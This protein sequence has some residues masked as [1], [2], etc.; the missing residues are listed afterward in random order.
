MAG[1]AMGLLAAGAVLHAATTRGVLLTVPQRDTRTDSLATASVDVSANGRYVAFE[2]LARLVPA[3]TNDR[4]DIY[5]LDLVTRIVT[6]ESNQPGAWID[7]A[8]PRLS[9]DGRFLVYESTP[10]V[11]RGDSYDAQI[12]WSDRVAGTSRVLTAT[13]DGGQSN[14]PSRAPDISD[15]GQTVVFVS[16]ASNLVAGDDANGRGDDV[17]AFDG[18][19]GSLSRVS[20]DTAGVQPATGISIAPTISGDGRWVVFASSAPL[21]PAQH[22]RQPDDERA[23]PRQIFARDLQDRRT[24]RV[25]QSGEGVAADD[26][27]WGP[28]VNRDGRFVAFVSDARN[29]GKGSRNRASDVFLH[30]RRTGATTLVSRAAD[31]GDASGSSAAPSIS[32]DGR[33][34]AFQSDAPNLTC[35][36]RCTPADEDI[37]LLW[38]VFVFDATSGTTTRMSEDEAG[39]WMEAS[40]GP[41][42]DASGAVL[43]FTSRHPID[44]LD[45]GDDYDVFVSLPDGNVR[46]AKH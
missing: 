14:G 1:K 45:R 41:S 15:D 2:S 43:A 12:V 36:R 3:D 5:V 20:V 9:A 21:V 28:A 38:D 46:T 42:I 16:N 34:V 35:A 31:G 39:E 29:L 40:R 6:L 8:R 18:R 23:E 33:Y 19:A 26:S 10:A 30:D 4:R 25:S 11:S 44:T 22:S 7:N 32:A 27:C 17:Y 37:N 13:P 24:V